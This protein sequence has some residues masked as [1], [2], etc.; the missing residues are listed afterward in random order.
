MDDYR[1]IQYYKNKVPAAVCP[2]SVSG[3]GLCHISNQSPFCI[4]A[5]RSPVLSFAPVVHVAPFQ[6][7]LIASL[8]FCC[9]SPISC[10]AFNS[11][12]FVWPM[13][14][15]G[16]A[17]LY[18]F[19]TCPVVMFMPPDGWAPNNSYLCSGDVISF[20]SVCVTSFCFNL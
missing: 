12:I 9:L 15:P 5:S 19:Q 2:T 16:T 8:C 13:L 1:Y 4:I 20:L 10:H 3:T 7:Q 18:P 6:Q 17:S 14:A 11:V